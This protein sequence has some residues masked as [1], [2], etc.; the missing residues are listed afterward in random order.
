MVAVVVDEG[1]DLAPGRAGNNRVT[2][3][4]RAALHD[5]RRHRA[6]AHFELGFEHA[7]AGTA[8]GA[9]PELFDLG[10]DEQ[11]LEQVVD[12]RALEG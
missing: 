3:A 4:Q 5:D 2:D 6:T 9:R 10:H 11:L 12:P 7:A 1:L 8:L